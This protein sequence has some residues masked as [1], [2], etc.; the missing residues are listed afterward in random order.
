MVLLILA[1]AGHP[2]AGSMYDFMDIDVLFSYLGYLGVSVNL[3]VVFISQRQLRRRHAELPPV[4]TLQS[5]G[6]TTADPDYA[7]VMPVVYAVTS[8]AATGLFLLASNMLDSG[9]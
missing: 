3:V 9:G 2:G 1:I 5:D 8:L 4:D 6:S 7:Y